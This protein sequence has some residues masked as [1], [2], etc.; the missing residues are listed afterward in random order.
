MAG[1][2]ARFRDDLLLAMIRAGRK[3]PGQFINPVP[4]VVEAGLSYMPGWIKQA[5]EALQRSD[6]VQA[7]F[8]RTGQPDGQIMAVVT[9][10]GVERGEEIEEERRQREQRIVRLSVGNP[11]SNASETVSATEINP[12][13]GTVSEAATAGAYQRGAFQG[14]GAYQ[15]RPRI[16]PNDPNWLRDREVMGRE[17]DR[18]IAGLNAISD[19]LRARPPGGIGHN[20]PPSPIDEPTVR[21][22]LEAA[23]EFRVQI[24]SDA[25]NAD[26]IHICEKAFQAVA[27]WAAKKVDVIVTAL[28]TA[29]VMRPEEFEAALHRVLNLVHQWWP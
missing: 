12:T 2:F 22:G 24:S 6:F 10:L 14:G 25:P 3:N 23:A 21:Y 27:A 7:R 13:A 4:V 17:A 18:I 20:Q 28:A 8:L 9:G 29:A 5:V 19:A 1:E 26:I 15:A 16:D 11:I